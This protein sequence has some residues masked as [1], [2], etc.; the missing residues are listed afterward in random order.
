MHHRAGAA[1]RRKADLVIKADLAKK[2]PVK[3]QRPAPVPEDLLAKPERVLGTL[4]AQVPAGTHRLI[5]RLCSREGRLLSMGESI[6]EWVQPVVPAP[7]PF[8][9]A[10]KE[11]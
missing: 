9:F 10:A 4:S 3:A 6:V 8:S 7:S 1:S 2:L 11:S 5:A